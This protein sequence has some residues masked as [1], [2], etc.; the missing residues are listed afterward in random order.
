MVFIGYP[1]SGHSLIGS[2]LDA[3]PEVIVSDEYNVVENWK[4]LGSLPKG[5]KEYK[6][7]YELFSLCLTFEHHLEIKRV[8]T[9]TCLKHDRERTE[10]V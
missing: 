3:H 2:L 7:F 6:L 1:R 10:T 8:T 9:T 4:K 5:T